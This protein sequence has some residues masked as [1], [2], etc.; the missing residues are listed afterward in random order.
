MDAKRWILWF[1][2]TVTGMLRT[3]WR[4][5]TSPLLD[6][7]TLGGMFMFCAGVLAQAGFL[8]TS[9]SIVLAGGIV[10]VQVER[11]QDRRR[12]KEHVSRAG[13][14]A[15][16]L[17]DVMRQCSL[18]REVSAQQIHA[19]WA[20]FTEVTANQHEP[21]EVDLELVRGDQIF[22]T[23]WPKGSDVGSCWTFF[24]DNRIERDGAQIFPKERT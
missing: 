7:V 13:E 21:G 24:P 10:T 5:A 15:Y 20:V 1:G 19:L 16:K 18:R 2:M 6:P 8:W 23:W 9:V 17:R 3:A 22:L 4:V 11:R 12:A 14:F